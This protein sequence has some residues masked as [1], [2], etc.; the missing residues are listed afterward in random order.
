MNEFLMNLLKVGTMIKLTWY[1]KDT[2]VSFI[3]DIQWL[4]LKW[5]YERE[6]SFPSTNL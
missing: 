1:P 2:S 4:S 3:V 5:V 6:K